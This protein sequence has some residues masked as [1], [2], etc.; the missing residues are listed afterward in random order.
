MKMSDKTSITSTPKEALIILKQA[1]KLRRATFLW[2]PPGIGKSELVEAFAK[3]LGVPM[4]RPDDETLTKNLTE[5]QFKEW[6]A[7]QALADLQTAVNRNAAGDH[8]PMFDVR[9]SQMDPVDFRGLP[10]KDDVTRT[11]GW[12]QPSDL[13]GAAYC[14]RYQHVVLFLDE[15]NSAPP[16][17]QAACYQLI[18]NRR[19]G[20]YRLPDNVIVIAAGNRS[21]DRGHV[22]AMPTPLANRFLHV[23]MEADFPSWREWAVVN[24]IHPDVV[25]YL[26]HYKSDLFCFK[27]D[28]DTT[29]FATPRT[30]KYVSDYLYLVAQEPCSDTIRRAYLAGLVGE[31]ITVKLMAHLKYMDE[32]MPKPADILSGKVAATDAAGKPTLKTTEVSAMYALATA[33]CYEMNEMQRSLGKERNGVINTLDDLAVCIDRFLMYSMKNFQPEICVMATV[34]AFNHYAIRVPASKLKNFSEFH[35]RFGSYMK[36]D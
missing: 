19:I 4:V 2:G 28:S 24:Q 13:P 10:Y 1:A 6:E 15:M 36:A 33:M 21:T 11:M 18:L 27:P 20:Q 31:G 30:W 23:H 26:S 34:I 25:G 3:E 8:V 22:Y 35:A 5:A 16:A 17:V 12:T 32:S 7:H 29:A 14:A 9:A